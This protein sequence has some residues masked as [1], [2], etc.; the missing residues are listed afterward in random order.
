M[1]KRITRPFIYNFS[2]SQKGLYAISVTASCKSGKLLGLFGGE[3][4]RVEIDGLKLREIPVKDKPQYKDIPSTWNGTKLKG[5]SKTIIFVLNLEQGE[6]KIN[7]I[8]YKGAII[9]KE[10]GIVL[11]D[12]RKEIKLL[13]GMQAQDG[14]RHPWIAIALINLPLNRLDVSVKC[15]KRFFDSDDVKI[16]IDNKIQKNQKAKFWAKNWYWQGRFLKGQTQETRFYPDLTKGVHYIEF[17]ADRKPTLNW[18][19]INLGQATEDKNI[20]QKYIYRGISGEEDYN[21]FDNEI[22]EAVQYWNDIFSKQEYPPEELLDPNLVKAMIF[23]ESRVGHEKGGEVDVM[24]V[25]N[26]GY[27]AI[28]TLNNDGSIIDPVTGQP[29][30]E[31]EIIDGKEQVLDYHGEANANTV[32]N[33]IHWGVRWLYHK[34]QR[35]TFDDKRYWRAWKKAV[36]RYGPGTDKYV[37]AIWNIYKNGIDPDNNILW[38]KKKNGFSLIK[39]LFIISAITI[40]FLTGCYLGTKL[41]ND[42]DLTL[43]EA[44][45]V[46][47]KIFFKE[48]EDYKNGKDYVFVG[49]SRECRK[50]DCIADLLFYKHYKLLVENMRDNQHFLNA[51]GYLYSPML[52]VRDIDN[53]GEN[54][55]IFSLYDPLNRDHIFLVIVDKINNKFQTI[56]KKM[57]GG[58][59]AYLQ[60]LDVTNDLQPEILLFMTQGRSGYPLYI[61]QYLENKELKQIFHSEFSLF[62]KFTFS[63]LDNDGLMEIKMQG[64]LKDAM[65]SY[66]A[67]VEIIH[68]YD[69]KTN[70]FIKIKEVEEEI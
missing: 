49:T 35:I 29:I 30:K 54:E 12:E 3:D 39:I 26:A 40:I 13:T 69:K 11:L 66:R 37:N 51:A 17:W 53:D 24:Q 36:K 27:S 48:I 61:Y 28:S 22:L 5:L 64:E 34:A 43:N 45:K 33:S 4:L 25:G 6:H 59:G 7:F 41:N 70:S 52:H 60:L 56:E 38:E 21:R 20:I 31:H 50:L 10:P 65:K 23:R 32:Y 1:F 67:N 62:P 57:N 68:E 18:V 63:D 19:K 16:I 44:Q 42:E 8:P 55:I 14:N 47:N 9:E 2:A 46:V 58:Y 15:E